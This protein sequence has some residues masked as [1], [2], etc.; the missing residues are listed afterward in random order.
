MRDIHDMAVFVRVVELGNLSAAGRDL[1]LSPAVVS[2]RIAKLE[3]RLEVRLLNRTTRK[4]NATEEGKIYYEHC[5]RILSEIEEVESALLAQKTNPKGVL[6][7]SAPTAYGRM[8]I[9]PLIPEFRKLCPEVEVRL[10]LTSRLVD[11]VEEGMDL[12]IRCGEPYATSMITR[13]I[14]DEFRVV[15]AT[16]EYLKT[17]GTP[18]VPEDLLHHNCLMMRFPGSKQF[19]WRFIGKDGPY[20]LEM[21]GNMDS[22]DG[23]VLTTWALQHQ[24]IILK[25]TWEIQNYLDNGELVSI[26]DDYRPTDLGIYVLFPHSRYLSPK[27]RAFIDFLVEKL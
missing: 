17:H 7:I 13:K 11:L 25:A 2:N 23:A 14:T 20:N 12:G 8:F 26:L 6:R 4:V 21:N 27:V 18:K 5:V 19:Q 1:R 10:Q 3:E 15:C 16:P 24:G 9:A 22:N